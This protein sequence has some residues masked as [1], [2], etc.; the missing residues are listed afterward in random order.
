MEVVHHEH[1]DRDWARL[2]R[3]IAGTRKALGITQPELA[4]K[5][6][7][8]RSSI[9]KMENEAHVYTKVLPVHRVIA[10]IL[11]W[12]E[13]SIEAILAGGEPVKADTAAEPQGV[14]AAAEAPA[15]GIDLPEGLSDRAKMAFFGGKVV[16][17]EVIDLAPDDPD[18]VALLVLKR[19]SRQDAS[20]EQLR[21]DL[22]KWA[23]LQRAA[24]E[25][26]SDS[27]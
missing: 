23:R 11:G 2:A 20:P 24:R 22:R 21:S 26:F 25:I 12:T 14:T 27:D 5:A 16:D 15:Q 4:R 8:G 19:G 17:S 18:A 3:T 13:D 9:Q 6:G 7:V 1:M 10:R